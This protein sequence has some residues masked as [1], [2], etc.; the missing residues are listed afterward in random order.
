MSL[1]LLSFWSNYTLHSPQ[2][3]WA[4]FWISCGRDCNHRTLLCLDQAYFKTSGGGH[5]R[6]LWKDV[7]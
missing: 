5:Q 2:H 4:G 7:L 1:W 6:R 3:S